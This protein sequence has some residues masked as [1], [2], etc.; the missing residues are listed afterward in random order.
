MRQS[1]K[2]EPQ[3][4]PLLSNGPR[5]TAATVSGMGAHE[6]S[7]DIV[8]GLPLI[9]PPHTGAAPDIAV[10]LMSVDPP[11]WKIW[12]ALAAV[13]SVR[14]TNERTNAPEPTEMPPPFAAPPDA[15]FP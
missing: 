6:L 12:L 4:P 13:L 9:V 10:P 2:D 15:R 14:V 8:F 3:V 5:S 11:S 7:L 1:W